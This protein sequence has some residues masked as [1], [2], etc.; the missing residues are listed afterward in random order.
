MTTQRRQ[1]DIRRIAKILR[2][3][4]YT[5]DESKDLFKAARQRVGLQVSKQK[6]GSV[7]RLTKDEFESFL[8]TAYS[9]SGVQGLL[10]RTLLE[11]GSRVSAFCR[12]HVEDISFSE[13]EIRITDKGDKT[14]DVPIL[15]SLANE[16]RLHLGGRESGYVFPSPRGGH[17]SARRLQQLVKEIAAEAGITKNVYPHLLRHTMAQY[18]ADQGMP[19]NLLQKFL[20]HEHPASTQVYYEPA[21]TQ[22]KRAFQDAMGS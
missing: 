3:G 18:L 14:R 6:K 1:Q 7:D 13:L 19:E 4:N 11:T 20:G 12:M 21:R 16:L 17:Y 15:R 22:V 2:D 9:R 10:I 8:N 5:Y